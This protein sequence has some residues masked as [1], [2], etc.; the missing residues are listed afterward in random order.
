MAHVLTRKRGYSEMSY[1]F[2]INSYWQSHVTGWKGRGNLKQI[3]LFPFK[4]FEERYYLGSSKRR[5]ERFSFISIQYGTS[6]T[7]SNDLLPHLDQCYFIT[8]MRY[9][10]DYIL[11][12]HH[13]RHLGFDL[14][15]YVEY[16]RGIYL[17]MK[18]HD[19]FVSASLSYISFCL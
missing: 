8:K 17:G 3:K 4:R 10:F 11:S 18:L 7:Q 5:R 13:Y 9:C 16:K 14:C 19:A 15:N 1:I 12:F 6:T 2:S